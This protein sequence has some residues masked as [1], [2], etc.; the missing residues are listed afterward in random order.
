MADFDIHLYFSENSKTHLDW[1]SEFSHFLGV[2]LSQIFENPPRIIANADVPGATFTKKLSHDE[3]SKIRAFVLVIGGEENEISDYN[4]VKQFLADLSQEQLS[5][6]MLVRRPQ[7]KIV[8]IPD[9]LKKFTAYNFYELAPNTQV[10]FEFNPNEKGIS[11][12]SFWERLTDLSYDLK[13]LLFGKLKV[14]VPETRANTIFLAEV[15]PDQ[16]KNRDRLRRELLLS[17]Y[18]ILPDSPLPLGLKEFEDEVRNLLEK[19]VMS[20]HMMGELYG[21]S[22]EGT[23]YSYQE[24]QNRLFQD[25]SKKLSGFADIQPKMNRVVWIQPIFD[26]YDE[27]EVQYIKRLRRDI[28]VSKDSELIQSTILDLKSIVDQKFALLKAPLDDLLMTESNEVLLIADDYRDIAFSAIKEELQHASLNFTLLKTL[29]NTHN[30]FGT[31]VDEMKKYKN[32]LVLN[33]RGDNA[34]LQSVLNLLVRS[35]GYIGAVSNS[36]VGLFSS[37]QVKNVPR[38][39]TVTIEPY[40]YNSKSINNI[41]Q[42]FITKLKT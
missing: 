20:I 8:E 2:I 29:A 16:Y 24:L 18:N 9:F 28:S 40:V 35:K 12:N 14:E 33:T 1:D 10:V 41:L 7:M 32:V 5:K 13:T 3:L 30:D 27:K 17:G 38:F 11:E 25:V 23:D 34:W 19:S 42:S 26:P 31:M 22:P 6:V 4:P 39:H 36:T 15:T 37:T 21:N